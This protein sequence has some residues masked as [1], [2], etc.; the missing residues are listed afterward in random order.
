MLYYVKS[1][2][3]MDTFGVFCFLDHILSFTAA[4]YKTFP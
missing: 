1:L 2:I 4:E 3:S